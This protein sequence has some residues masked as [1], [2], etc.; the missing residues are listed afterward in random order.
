MQVC[1]E[2]ES[3]APRAAARATPLPGARAPGSARAR[4]ARGRAGP[5][6]SRRARGAPRAPRLFAYSYSIR[7]AFPFSFVCIRHLLGLG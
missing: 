4:L 1:R 7:F 3:R 2:R 5:S 6:R